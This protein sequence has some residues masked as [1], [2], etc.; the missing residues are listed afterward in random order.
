FVQYRDAP[1]PFGYDVAEITATD[2]PLVLYHS[3][4]SQTYAL[5]RSIRLKDLLLRLMPRPEPLAGAGPGPLFILAEPGLGPMLLHYLVR[6][7]VEASCGIAEWPPE[8]SFDEAPRKRW[9]FRI[10]DLPARMRPTIEKTPGLTS[11]S[12]VC[13]GAAVERTFRHPVSL[14][15]CP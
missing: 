4:F 12:P 7:R 8:T 11:F 1:A 15:A 6:S 2:A 13:P 14:R 3:T 9:L 10:P 5:D